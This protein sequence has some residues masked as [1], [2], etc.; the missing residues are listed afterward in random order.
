MSLAPLSSV[1]TRS[2]HQQ[3]PVAVFECKARANV[4][5]AFKPYLPKQ[6][7]LP[8]HP[9]STNKRLPIPPINPFEPV[10]KPPNHLRIDLVPVS[11]RLRF[12][13]LD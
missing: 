2:L 8:S 9:S 11:H 13:E 4:Q 5:I 6:S 7:T 12:V 3:W 1:C 10:T